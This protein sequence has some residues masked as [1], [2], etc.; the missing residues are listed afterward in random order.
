VT[1][2]ALLSEIEATGIVLHAEGDRVRADIPAGANLGPFREH[3]QAH[4]A[5]LHRELLQRQ[6]VAAASAGPEHFDRERYDR[7][8][9][10]WHALPAPEVDVAA[11]VLS[12]DQGWD[13][14]RDHPTHPEH[15]LF[16]QRWIVRLRQYER[17]YCP[18]RA[19]QDDEI[20]LPSLRSAPAI[21][22]ER[23][24]QE[25]TG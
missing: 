8:W 1:A 25:E 6:I 19:R 12:L 10:H 20:V 2:T 4:K 21:D 15:D 24:A 5:A 11:L 13:W 16:L 17:T 18:A 23:A 22:T 3:I 7:L 14:L 9:Q